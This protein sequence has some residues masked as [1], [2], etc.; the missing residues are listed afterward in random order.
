VKPIDP[1]PSVVVLGLDFA[2]WRVMVTL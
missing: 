1:P 2:P